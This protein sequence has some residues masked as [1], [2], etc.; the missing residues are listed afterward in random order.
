MFS[1]HHTDR[2]ALHW[3]AG[4]VHGNEKYALLLAVVAAIGEVL[5]EKSGVDE[6]C[7]AH[8]FASGDTL[9]GSLEGGE[10]SL[11]NTM[12]IHQDFSGFHGASNYKDKRTIALSI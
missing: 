10:N 8:I 2:S 6:K 12:F 9:C 4:F 7:R 11:D 1:Q 5:D 3:H